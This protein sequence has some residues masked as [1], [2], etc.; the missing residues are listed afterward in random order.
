MT[1][2]GGGGAPSKERTDGSIPRRSA[3]GLAHTDSNQHVNSLV[4]PRLFEDAALRR[5]AAL[6]KLKPPVLARHVEAAF[7]KPCFAG[8][9]YVIAL[10]AFTIA[11]KLGAV[12]AF[13]SDGSVT[14][15]P[16]CCVRMMF[17]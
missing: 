16:H 11:G 5:F 7:R 17:D 10:Q 14:A 1:L 15:R 4:Y 3:F 9:R 8:E 2:P 6:G 12:G 13:L